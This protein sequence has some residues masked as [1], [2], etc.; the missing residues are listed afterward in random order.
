VSVENE[1]GIA[2][3][4]YLQWAW[5][6]QAKKGN[7][8]LWERAA[9]R[10]FKEYI[11]RY[12][13]P[14]AI[15]AQEANF[16]GVFASKIKRKLG[17]PYILTEHS[18]VYARGLVKD[19]QI[20]NLRDAFRYADHR[21]VVSPQLGKILETKLG[22]DVC[23]WKPIPNILDPLFSDTPLL[24][25]E[26]P[27]KPFRFLN[28]ALMTEKK[29]QSDLLEAFSSSFN[30]I[31]DVELRLGGDGPIREDLQRLTTKL[32][33]ES[34][35]RFLGML[36][37]Q[38]V[39]REMQDCD[40]FVLPSYIET[41]GVV[42]IEALACGKPILSTACGGPESIVNS[43]NGLIVSP[44]D[45]D[46]LSKGLKQMY[47]TKDK[48]DPQKIRQECLDRYGE[49]VIVAQLKALFIDAIQGSRRTVF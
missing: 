2:V 5:L 41:F 7:L 34:K 10:I 28:V 40:I 31:E 4:R 38:Q 49:K 43:N 23:P 13:L 46:A 36:N 25:R 45:I 24:V 47:L 1:D 14:D 30:G 18:T 6:S 12:G 42:L 44:K 15:H 20:Q 39:L 27:Q 26:L 8:L 16:A 35:V 17:I 33:I 11:D 48:Y 21:V 32:G 3:F 37:R 19:W 9:G 29:G 22:S